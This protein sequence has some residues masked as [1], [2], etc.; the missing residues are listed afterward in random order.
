MR[1]LAAAPAAAGPP[2]HHETTVN[3][4]HRLLT[5]EDGQ[6][7]VEYALLAS[8]L[9]FAA[10]VGAEALRLAMNTTYASW[11][12]AAQSDALVEVPDPK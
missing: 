4:W 5:S 6:D 11:D 3:L 9:G 7:I 12:A 1:G 10:M 8:F 2:F